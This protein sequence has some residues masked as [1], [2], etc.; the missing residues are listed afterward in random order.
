MLRWIKKVACRILYR[1]STLERLCLSVP[2]KMSTVHKDTL[3][4]VRNEIWLSKK[5][6][7]GLKLIWVHL[8]LVDVEFTVQGILDCKRITDRYL[9]PYCYNHLTLISY[10]RQVLTS[11]FE[12]YNRINAFG[13]KI[14]S[15]QKTAYDSKNEEHETL[16]AELWS[17]LKPNVR[18]TGRVTK[19]WSEIG[20][21][22]KCSILYQHYHIHIVG[23]DPKTDF[24]LV[25]VHERDFIWNRGMGVLSLHQL[26]YF[27]K[28]HA[29][30]AQ[31]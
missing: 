5:I 30:A 4:R 29:A 7:D 14:V 31:R 9:N 27:A 15:L 25:L 1:N 28:H 23:D 19:E 22:G 24:R 20:F 2:S 12:E 21:Q 16:L 26:V 3:V 8:D 17:L 13:A 10:V 11:C 6:D 18:R